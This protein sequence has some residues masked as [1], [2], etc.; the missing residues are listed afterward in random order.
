L[1]AVADRHGK[2]CSLWWSLRSGFSVRCEAEV[3]ERTV[4]LPVKDELRDPAAPEQVCGRLRDLHSAPLAASAAPSENEDPVIVQLTKVLRLEARVIAHELSHVGQKDSTLM[5]A[6]G[7]PGAAMLDGGEPLLLRSRW[8]FADRPRNEE[9]S[10]GAT[11]PISRWG[12]AGLLWVL[13]S[14]LA[15]SPE[16]PV[17]VHAGEERHH[18]AEARQ[19]SDWPHVRYPVESG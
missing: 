18:S 8:H 1:L 4:A 2:A 19:Q 12:S 3:G 7:A 16:P 17:Q 15:G 14:T 6:V 10:T 9:S 11:R 5:S 13:W